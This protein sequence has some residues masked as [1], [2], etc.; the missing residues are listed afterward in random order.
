[1]SQKSKKLSRFSANLF[2]YC[3][4]LFLLAETLVILAVFFGKSFPFQSALHYFLSIGVGLSGLFLVWINRHRIATAIPPTASKKAVKTLTSKEKWLIWPWLYQKW[5]KE[6]LVY[7]YILAGLLVIGSV[8]YCY[9]LDYYD[10]L[11]DEP[12]VVSAAKGYV[13]TGS[14]T[15]WDFWMNQPGTEKYER[16]WPHTW[17]VAQSIRFFGLSE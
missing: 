9:D 6:P 3:F 13:E 7:R 12:L 16:A 14:F 15:R 5:Q 4:L 8:I 2:S 11:P 1:M 17:L 10:W